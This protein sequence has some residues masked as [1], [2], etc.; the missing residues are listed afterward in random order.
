[1]GT[2]ADRQLGLDIEHLIVEFFTKKGYEVKLSED[3]YDQIK[4][5]TLTLN[6][7]T[8]TLE[9][10]LQTIVHKFNSFTV[11]ISSNVNSD[12]V[13]KNQLSKCT[14]VDILIFC[15][16]PEPNDEVLRIYMAPPRGKR[17]FEIRQN[18][19]DKRYVAHF[20]VD[21]MTLLGTITDTDVVQKYMRYGVE[22]YAKSF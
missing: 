1:M 14:N 5:L 12:G 4:D 22:S 16:R 11:P 17:Y 8:Y 10:K 21:K 6:G 13:F 9:N 7:K 2:R 19:Y 20:P 15:Q 18:G 3:D